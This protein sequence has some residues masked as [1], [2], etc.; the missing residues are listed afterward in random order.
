MGPLLLTGGSGFVGRGLLQH[1]AA[2][3]AKVT[4]LTRS[5]DA[6]RR[7]VPPAEGWQYLAGDI[8][9]PSTYARQLAGIHT[10]LHLAAV[11]GR[12]PASQYAAVIHEGT[13]RL[14]R[15]CE[16]RGV[17]RF[18]FVSSIAAGFA[19]RRYYPYAEA[20]A[21]AEDAVRGSRTD[22][23]I[24][25]PTMVFG[26]GSPVLKGLVTLAGALVGLM[27]GTGSAIVQPIDRDD[28]ALILNSL[29]SERPGR[30]IIEVGGPDQLSLL[31][32]LRKIRVELRGRPGPMIR[33]PLELMRRAL[34]LIEPTS[35][36]MLPLTA[37]Q[38]APFAND[39][40]ARRH[41]RTAPFQDSLK[42]VDEMLA[43]LPR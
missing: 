29:V 28:L 39:G 14:V 30:E 13:R 24:V 7:A 21:R 32:L 33:L 43:T 1:L 36:G 19:D 26:R 5:P 12:A 37:G 20:K 11:T 6:L 10:V 8:T 42:G 38:L 34:A 35:L 18:V 9:D 41:P 27:P 17:P 15:A 31:D 16:D 25:R 23:L 3:G 40:I 4:L 2:T 22:W